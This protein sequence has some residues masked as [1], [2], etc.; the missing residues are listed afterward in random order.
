MQWLFQTGTSTPPSKFK[1]AVSPHDSGLGC[2]FSGGT[3]V[4][5]NQDLECRLSFRLALAVLVELCLLNSGECSNAPKRIGAA[6]RW[7]YV[8]M[9]AKTHTAVMYSY[10]RMNAGYVTSLVPEH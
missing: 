6:E 3:L 9:H 8:I 1:H 2:Y 4:C 7:G 5:F 10:T